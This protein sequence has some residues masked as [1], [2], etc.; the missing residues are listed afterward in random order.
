MRMLQIGALAVWCDAGDHQVRSAVM[1]R[2]ADM[3]AADVTQKR[4]ARRRRT[5]RHCVM[6]A[7]LYVSGSSQSLGGAGAA[8]A[9]RSS[10]LRDTLGPCTRMR[11]A[12]HS[13]ESRP[14]CNARE[15]CA[16]GN[17]ARHIVAASA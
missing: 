7:I 11:S 1:E 8:A 17:Q 6:N 14:P 3:A 2:K 9:A 10:K 13:F 12:C 5:F 15:M 4:R 16:F